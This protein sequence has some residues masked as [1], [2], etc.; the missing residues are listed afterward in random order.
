MSDWNSVNV[1]VATAEGTDIIPYLNAFVNFTALLRSKPK[2][3]Q[4]YFTIDKGFKNL[5]FVSFPVINLALQK[6]S[7]NDFL[8]STNLLWREASKCLFSNL[9]CIQKTI[10]TFFK[11]S[12]S[13]EMY[14]WNCCENVKFLSILLL[15][16]SDIVCVEWTKSSFRFFIEILSSHIS[17]DG[18]EW[19]PSTWCTV[20][21]S[22]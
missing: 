13:Y 4:S 17:V 11:F 5:F 8:S 3:W 21:I 2:A 1:G 20:P 6:D 10:N 19:T 12:T 18:T 7:N 9:L 16:G 15:Y 22:Y 14:L